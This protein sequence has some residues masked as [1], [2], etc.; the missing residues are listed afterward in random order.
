MILTNQ[1]F[2]RQWR[3]GNIP[4]DIEQQWRKHIDGYHTQTPRDVGLFP[5]RYRVNTIDELVD[6]L[7]D[8]KGYGMFT[9]LYS[10]P[11][12]EGD[13]Y[14]TIYI[15]ID[16]EVR[17]EEDDKT[18]DKVRGFKQTMIQAYKAMDSLT[19]YIRDEYGENPRVIFSGGRGFA[20]YIDFEPLHT[21]F[22]AIEYFVETLVED[23]PVNDDLVDTQVV[24]NKRMTRLPY[25]LHWKNVEERGMPEPLLTVPVSPEWD[26]E[27]CLDEILNPNKYIDVSR[28]PVNG[29]REEIKRISEE[30]PYEN[31]S[32]TQHGRDYDS[33][34]MEY[35]PSKQRN[36]VSSVEKIQRVMNSTD[37]VVDGR[38]RILWAVLIPASLE[39]GHDRN[40]VRDLAQ[41]FVE[42]TGES[43]T[44]YADYVDRV[45]DRT[46]SGPGDDDMWH[47]WSVEK[48]A[49]TFPKLSGVVREGQ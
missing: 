6:E 38:K 21:P 49:V 48:F 37:A 5:G 40:E 28:N 41:Q 43:Y 45:I 3:D 32:T 7:I 13:I 47:S 34:T 22:E 26:S 31:R 35:T 10:D 33:E 36:V 39:V 27:T 16:A 30:K 23:A 12:I 2:K 46:I 17:W 24:E 18:E 9:N 14:G 20:I 1:E 11:Q 44:D 19:S 4:V 25:T 8:H 15:D 42:N 29:V